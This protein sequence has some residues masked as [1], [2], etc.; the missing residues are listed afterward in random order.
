MAR[1]T[2][3]VTAVMAR[4][5][6]HQGEAKAHSTIATFTHTGGT[7]ER[8]KN[9]LAFLLWHAGSAVGNAEAGAA[10]VEGDHGCLNG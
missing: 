5:L 1:H 7:V 2:P 4:N 3:Y 6:A 9:T 8:R 10:W